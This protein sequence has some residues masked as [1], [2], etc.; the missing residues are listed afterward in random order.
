MGYL[1]G[2]GHL[3]KADVYGRS[4]LLAVSCIAPE[5]PPKGRMNVELDGMRNSPNDNA[6]AR[7]NEQK[8]SHT[9]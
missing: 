8:C 7:Q 1:W 9:S 5:Q 3:S 6:C 4:R 2:T